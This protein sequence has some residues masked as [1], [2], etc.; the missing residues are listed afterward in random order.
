MQDATPAQLETLKTADGTPLKDSIRKSERRARIR[1]FLLVLPLL[2]FL[3]I[4]FIVPIMAMMGRSVYNPE[5]V[6][7]LPN[8]A[9]ALQEW[10][11]E[12][13]PGEDVF[14]AL[15]K[16]M[17]Q[18]R[19]DRTIGRVAARINR[20]LPGAR[21]LMLGTARDADEMQPPY[22]EAFIAEDDRW[23][24]PEFW[25][26]LKRESRLITPSYYLLALDYEYTPQGNIE[27]RPEIYQV[28]T[29]LFI[30]TAWMSVLITVLCILLA[31]PVSYLLA[32]LP[33][34]YSNL[35]MILVLLPFWTSLLVR[36]SA[37]I[38][39]LQQEGVI[40]DLLVG[41]GFISDD[42]RLRM[43]YNQTGTIVAMT[44]ILLPFM[45]LPLY[46]VMKTINPSYLRAARSLGATPLVAWFRVYFPLT[47]P[48][49]AAG[50]MLVFILAIG[51]YITPA[52]V[53]GETGIFISN[54]IA[55]N[56]QGS[57]AQ[58]RL[59]AA[60]ATIL[61]VLVML[62]YWLFNKLVGVERLKFG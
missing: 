60:L 8:T 47:L 41:A 35:L 31:Y 34:R 33:L 49:L 39:L 26:I 32:T 4:T 53:G 50:V 29:D 10:E 28:Y 36:T 54:M 17:V 38:V 20:E 23:T 24:N 6:N 48:G 18:G 9:E 12:G 13:V 45:I 27:P 30:R 37:W 59:A 55:S 62:F 61:L 42:G 5:V 25:G 14:A 46:S 57:T 3:V 51:Y 52:L 44:H 19:E 16:D 15:A 11:G 40:N 1:A 7:Y 22:K 2:A 21:S 58:L 56:M 43:I